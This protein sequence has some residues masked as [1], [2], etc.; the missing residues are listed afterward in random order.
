MTPNKLLQRSRVD[1]VLGRGR[2]VGVLEQA[3]R[4]RVLK[5]QWP[6]AEWGRSARSQRIVATI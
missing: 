3:L 2:E 6:A 5:S 4:A 1:R